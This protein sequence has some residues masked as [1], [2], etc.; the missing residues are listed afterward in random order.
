[1]NEIPANL[2]NLNVSEADDIVRS[3]LK[4]H[5]LEHPTR[6][7]YVKSGD[8]FEEVAEDID[9]RFCRELFGMFCESREYLEKWTRGYSGSYRYRI[10]LE[11]MR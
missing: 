5:Y 8:L 6:G 2:K 4:Q 11:A 1:M 7:P 9:D 10:Q 3:H